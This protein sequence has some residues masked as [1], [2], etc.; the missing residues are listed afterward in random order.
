MIPHARLVELAGLGHDCCGEAEFI[1]AVE[2]F[3]D[4]LGDEAAA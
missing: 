4:D 2:R 3:L 1:R